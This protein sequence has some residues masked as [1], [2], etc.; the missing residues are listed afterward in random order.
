MT[1]D[2]F[3]ESVLEAAPEAIRPLSR[4]MKRQLIRQL[5]RQQHVQGRL[6]HFGPIA[7]TS[8]LVDLLCELISE[9][10]R[11]EIWPEHFRRACDARGITQKDVELLA[12]YDEYQRCLRENQLYDAEGRFWSARDRLGQGQRRPLERLRLVM[13]D[14]FTDF[15]RTQHE[16]LEILARRVD[17]LWITLPLETEPRRADLFGKPLGTLAELRR[18]HRGLVVEELPRAERPSWPALAQLEKTLFADPRRV[19]PADDLAGVEI[20]AAAQPLGEIEQIGARIKRL[21]TQGDERSVEKPGDVEGDSPIF[22][23]AK[24]GTVP[25]KPEEIAV[26]F[27][28]P[29]DTASLVAEVFGALGIPL[30]SE[31]G[32][33]LD[34]SP[35]L[36]ALV[37]LLRLDLDDW[38]FGQLLH[39]LSSN[40][41]QPA[42]PEWHEGKTA[43]AIERTVRRLQIPR[44]RDRL[45]AELDT[46]SRTPA[47][48]ATESGATAGLPSS[49]CDRSRRDTAGQASS[50]TRASRRDTA[51]QAS[52]GTLA[53]LRRLAAALDALPQQAGPGDWAEAWG[54]LAAETGLL[55]AIGPDDATPIG[56]VPDRVAWARLRQAL[57]AAESFG[58]QLRQSPIRWD[59]RQAVDAMLD[60]LSS[61]RVGH[62][63]DESGRVRVMSAAS[64]RALRIPYLFLAGLSEKAFPPP[65][66]IDRLYSEA[67]YQRLI[68]EGLPLVARSER[69][70]EEMLLFYEAMTRATRRLVLSY[71]ALDA[72]AQPLAASPFLEE[73]DEATGGRIPRTVAAD[74]SPIPQGDEPLSLAEFRV[75]AVATALEGDVALLAGLL[76]QQPQ[77]AQGILAGIGLIDGRQD[78]EHFGP[79]EGI[80]GQPGGAIAACG[81]LSGRARLQRHRTRTLCLVPLS[82]LPRAGTADRAGRGN[83]RGGRLPRAWATGTRGPGVVPPAGQ[84]RAG[85]AGLARR[86]GSGRVRPPIGRVARR[87]PGRP[88]QRPAAG[89]TARGRPSAA[90]ALA[91]RLSGST[92]DLR[93][94]PARGRECRSCPSGSRSRSDAVPKARNDAGDDAGERGPSTDRPLE[95][96]ATDQD[97]CQC[98]PCRSRHLNFSPT[99]GQ[100]AVQAPAATDGVIRIAGRIDRIDR[101]DVDGTTVFNMVDYKTGG[102]IRLT[103]ET[104]AEGTT[105]QLPLYALAVAELMLD[106]RDALPWQAGYWYLRDK[107]FKPAGSEMYQ[108]ADGGL[109]PKPEWEEIRQ[110]LARRSRPWPEASAPESSPSSAPTPTVRAAALTAPYA[111]STRFARWRSH[112][113]RS[114][115]ASDRPEWTAEQRRAI[116][117]RGRFGGAVGGGGLRQDVRADR[118]VPGRVAS[119]TD[120]AAARRARA[121]GSW[122]PSP[123]PSGPRGKCATASARPV[124][125]SSCDAPRRQ[126]DYWLDLIRELDSA[127]ISTI[128]SFC[129]VA[130][131]GP[132]GRGRPRPAVP[133]A[134]AGAGRH[135]A[136]RAD[137]RAA[138][139]AA[140]RSRRGGH[141]PGGGV[142][143]GA[144]PR[145]GPHAAGPAAGDRLGGLAGRTAEGL[146]AR[147]EDYLARPSRGRRIAAPGG[148]I[149]RGPDLA[150]D[151]PVARPASHARC[152]SVARRSVA[153]LPELARQQRSAG[154]PGRGPRQ[155]PGPGRGRQEGVAERGDLRAS[156]A[157]RRRSCGIRSTRSSDSLG[158]DA[159]AARPAAETALR[160]LALAADV[161]EEYEPQKRRR[162][163][164]DFDDLLIHARAAAGRARPGELRRRLAS[165]IR[166]LLVDEFQDT[167]PLQVEL[168]KALCDDAPARRGKLFFVGDYKQS[169]YRFRGADP[170]VFRRASRGDIPRRGPPAADAQL[171]QPAGRS[172]TSSTRCSATSSARSTSRWR[173]TARR[174]APRPASSCSGRPT[175]TRGTSN[176]G[177][178]TDG[179]TAGHLGPAKMERAAPARGRLDRPAA[180]RDARRGREIVWDDEAAR[181]GTPAVRAVQPGDVALLFRALSDVEYLRGGACAA[182]GST[183]TWS[184]GTPSMPSRRSTTC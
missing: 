33:R 14:G 38:P 112:G 82:L 125:A 13:A 3:A 151:R 130:A 119:P 121:S 79:A 86:T 16:I 146:V 81:P 70:H 2:R 6:T 61:E 17:E 36:G 64:A 85:P 111:A 1:F 152:G 178:S 48:G 117:A 51:G 46:E 41:F 39:V 96:C 167:D 115:G 181:A 127:R 26:V 114:R 113:S 176:C 104:I 77:L 45:L 55:R 105:L 9:L 133:R 35:V 84:R 165:Q 183:T 52:S 29:D 100:P 73:M 53:V 54:R 147:W 89:R 47:S 23:D 154:R 34:R 148:P 170:Q 109:A 12:I 59:R 135:A 8:G 123:S 15:T 174:S 169:I 60:I 149:G 171:P 42:W 50:G 91:H 28:S 131:A 87:G 142:R 22:A 94:A 65:Q 141:R 71:P 75:K 101:A 136:L 49:A 159:E 63:E 144:A 110:R 163:R 99:A 24:I 164:L 137:R 134:G 150:R 145:D 116:G 138:P 153:K 140:G 57:A 158:F 44:G 126:V 93:R 166:L 120:A 62:A 102:P 11:L 129:G 25:V 184:A 168:V 5:I 58:P 175:R 180:P 182:T 27:R 74:L 67:E 32:N 155:R 19:S 92:R 66:R 161:A 156:S 90:C 56:G 20:L 139:R 97:G 76:G 4:Q 68:D 118:A 78:R 37:S 80:L 177:W 30:A 40:Y 10:K 83:G 179:T 106:D 107:G 128:H 18:R 98:W 43:A 122:W 160:L 21:L 88:A 132:R 108:R 172:S 7:E 143:P 69:N 124:A 173:P 103:P 72:A 157:T 95:F 162:G 31:V